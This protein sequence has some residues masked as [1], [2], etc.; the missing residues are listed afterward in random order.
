MKLKYEFSIREI[1]GDYVIVP[2]GEAALKISGMLTTNEVG[3]FI[4]KQ[5]QNDI[6]EDE[7]L[8]MLVNEFAVEYEEG[9]KDLEE[10]LNHARKLNV[11]IE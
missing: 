5:L 8:G 2:L 7:L 6:T 9:K 4:W 10:F 1:M 11:L 3:A